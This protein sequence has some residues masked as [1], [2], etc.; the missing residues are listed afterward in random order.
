MK[1]SSYDKAMSQ[2]DKGKRLKISAEIT[3]TN[4]R[5]DVL[6]ISRKIRQ[7]AIVELTVPSEERIVFW[8][9]KRSKYAQIIE[10]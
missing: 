1:I 9:L 10:E 2:A 3:V 5:P 4:L 8:E 7:M 6:I